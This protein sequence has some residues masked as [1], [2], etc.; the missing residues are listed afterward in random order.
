[1]DEGG[2]H[3]DSPDVIEESVS[4]LLHQ[5]RLRA[6]FFPFLRVLFAFIVLKGY[7][8]SF[9]VIRRGGGGGG[10]EHG[11]PR[12]QPCALRLRRGG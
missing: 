3:V 9:A 11:L 12:R 7:C 2:C 1:M 8:V 5:R 4:T 6:N 10:E